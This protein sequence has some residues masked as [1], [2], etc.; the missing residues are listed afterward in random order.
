VEDPFAE[1]RA[2]D[3]KALRLV[4]VW[5]SICAGVGALY[6]LLSIWIDWK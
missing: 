5:F 3:K 2:E 6:L 4:L 1:G